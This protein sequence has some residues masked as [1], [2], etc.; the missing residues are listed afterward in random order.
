MKVFWLFNHPAPYK[1][2]FFN[3]LGKSCELTVCFERHSEGDRNPS[4]YAEKA[5]NFKMLL[6]HSLPLGD[7]NNYTDLPIKEIKKNH[8]DVIVINGWS[9][10]TEMR[11]ISYLKKHN[12][13]YVFAINGG[14]I[15]ENEHSYKKS[16]KQKFL[17]GAAYY[18]S[19]DSHSSKYLV[20]YGVD[21]ALIKL[22][23]YSTVFENEIISK[24][25]A[26]EERYRE[27]EKLG[28]KG[29]ELYINVG[30]FIERKNNMELL[31]IWKNV[32]EDKTLLLVG[33]GKEKEKYI[34]YI[35]A[36]N[37]HNVF[38]MPFKSH[39]DVL[40][41]F[42]ISDCSIFL[43]KEDIYGHVVNECLSQGT[44]VI[45]SRSA[46]S[47]LNLIEDGKNGFLVD[48]DNEKSIM[49]AIETEK[50]MDMDVYAMETSKKNTLEIMAARHLAIFTEGK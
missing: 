44:P 22:Y 15:R 4:F 13:P 8:Y 21:P 3:L 49:D 33:G 29:N 24:P 23:P 7:F 46:N 26:S 2:D 17:P 43:T 31:R 40:H 35:K 47:A 18:L 48:L 19:P 30:S 36:H 34:S 28:I 32:A 25:L 27:R 16:L 11:C 10:L 42:S 5:K 38:L 1:V 14:V 41:L 6:P 37:L 45:A 9:T 12:I 20:Y 39:Q 50:D